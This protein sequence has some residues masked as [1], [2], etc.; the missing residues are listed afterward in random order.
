MN[1]VE[2]MENNEVAAGCSGEDNNNS[3]G[4]EKSAMKKLDSVLQEHREKLKQNQKNCKL[5]LKI[6][7]F[8]S[9]LGSQPLL[10]NNPYSNS[11]MA[12]SQLLPLPH[13]SWP[14]QNDAPISSSSNGHFGTIETT[15]TTGNTAAAAIGG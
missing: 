3:S 7:I 9:L 14:N 1:A 6:Y 12:A 10:L 4:P 5:K 8:C 11:N 15:D 2:S 13:Q